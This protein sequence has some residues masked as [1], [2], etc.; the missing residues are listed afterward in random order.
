MRKDLKLA[1]ACV[2]VLE[3]ELAKTSVL[4]G[5]LKGEAAKAKD[6]FRAHS[7]ENEGALQVERERLSCTEDKYLKTEGK[8]RRLLDIEKD[9]HTATSRQLMES[10]AAC[11][12][13][14]EEIL[15]KRAVVKAKLVMSEG[16]RRSLLIMEQV[17]GLSAPRVP[18][19]I[20][21]YLGVS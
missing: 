3:S 8:L 11:I 1:N 10:G 15:A 14:R 18:L 16:E 2:K 17:L 9:G 21:M 20:S 4:V 12:K 19:V 7:L 5:K 13:E 6:K